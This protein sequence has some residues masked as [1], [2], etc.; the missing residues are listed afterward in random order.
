MTDAI[1]PGGLLDRSYEDVL[2]ILGGFVTA[3]GIAS[4][5]A[6]RLMGEV[7]N[8]WFLSQAKASR[9]EGRCQ[10]SVHTMHPAI[11]ASL[12]AVRARA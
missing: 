2:L 6:W 7:A 12:A 10:G 5:A 11:R 9:L 1:D 4:D 3:E 8:S